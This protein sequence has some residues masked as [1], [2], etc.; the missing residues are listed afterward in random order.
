MLLKLF[1]N[2]I[3]TIYLPVFTL[4]FFANVAFVAT[5][6]KK[7][8]ELERLDK[9]KLIKVVK[10]EMPV[11]RKLFWLAYVALLFSSA[12]LLFVSYLEGRK[13][14]G[15][16]LLILSLWIITS[17]QFSIFS[18]LEIYEKGILYGTNFVRWEE[19]DQEKFKMIV[20]ERIGNES[21]K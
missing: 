20:R 15:V 6:L 19:M 3:D 2:L 21:D 18:K 14:G 4:L 13:I 8:R 7:K 16:D 5:F 9:G 11:V 17:F 10:E 1:T 12:S